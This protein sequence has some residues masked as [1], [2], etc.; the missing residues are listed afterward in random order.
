[1]LLLD[2]E[3]ET[4]Y[5]HLTMTAYSTGY[6]PTNSQQ[7]QE[8][9]EKRRQVLAA[10]RERRKIISAQFNKKMRLQATNDLATML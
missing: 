5:Y 6:K 7:V 4:T 8:A 10:V 3:K 1:M 9:R 2:T